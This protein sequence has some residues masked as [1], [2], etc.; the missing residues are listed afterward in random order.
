MITKS[1]KIMAFIGLAWLHGLD[2]G[3]SL[4]LL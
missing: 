1:T 2:I 4:V 3:T